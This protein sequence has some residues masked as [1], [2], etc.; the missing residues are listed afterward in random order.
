MN[1]PNPDTYYYAIDVCY[2]VDDNFV[3]VVSNK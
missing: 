3:E 2:D 1:L